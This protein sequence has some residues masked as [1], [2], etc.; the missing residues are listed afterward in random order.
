[1][2]NQKMAEDLWPNQ[3]PIGK[4]V[5]SLSDEQTPGV[6][7]PNVASIVVGVVSNTHHDSLDDS[8]NDEVY[9]PITRTHEAPVMYIVMR[10]Q[11]GAEQAAE[12]LRRAV[13][14]IDPLVPVTRVRTMNE[15]VAASDSASRSL[16]FLLLGFGALAV[17]IGVI[18][19]YSLIA[20]IVSW[21]T[22]EIGIRL[23]LGARRAQIVGGVVKQSM[24]LAA[25]GS[26]IGLIAAAVTARLLRSF[27]FEV[28]V[29]DPVTFCAVPVMM[30]L[31]ALAAAWIPARR[32]ASVDP[33]EALRVE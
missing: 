16:T 32:A 7:D 1:V 9:L 11:T 26:L 27:L 2:I 20:Y 12:G 25:G 5:I 13:A 10:T 33:M 19:V 15:V 23:A 21:R 6:M 3:D 14:A 18:G 8:F 29:L 30:A 28:S 31:L 24:L 22:R 4:H 17:L